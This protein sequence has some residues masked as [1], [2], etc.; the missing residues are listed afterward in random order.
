MR[1]VPIVIGLL[2]TL[3]YAASASAHPRGVTEVGEG[4]MRQVYI[5]KPLVGAH[6]YLV[7]DWEKGDVRVH[8]SKFPASST[9]YEVF[10]FQ[11]DMPALASKLFV[12]GMM[13]NGVVPNPPPMDEVAG[14]ISQ[15]R[16]I[17]DLSMDGKGG[18]TLEFK[19]G[20]NLDATG[21]NMIMIF[22][23][24]TPGQHAGPED[25][26]KLIVECNGP[27]A[28]LSSTAGMES[29]ITVFA[30]MPM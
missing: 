28:G 16:S 8:V 30:N 1:K 20:G 21:L 24:A 22:E 27:L 11:I 6:G 14:L 29:S 26:S 15:W 23:K 9:G 17:G 18:G 2:A 10:L 13:E 25:M 12:G 3:F 5:D 4:I 7:A 19:G